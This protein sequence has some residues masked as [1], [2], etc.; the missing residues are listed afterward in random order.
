MIPIEGQ[1]KP[2]FPFLGIRQAN[3]VGQL[4]VCRSQPKGLLVAGSR[5][6]DAPPGQGDS[7]QTGTG[8]QLSA[9]HMVAL[10]TQIRP[11]EH[12]I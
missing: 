11:L 1:Q 3:V 9:L 8:R 4:L 5:A 10:N 6:G 7:S 12:L 2:C